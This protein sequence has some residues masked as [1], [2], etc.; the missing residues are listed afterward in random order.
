MTSHPRPSD[1]LRP[2]DDE[3]LVA[4]GS[5]SDELDQA[6]ADVESEVGKP[7]KPR[8]TEMHADADEFSNMSVDDADDVFVIDDDE[9]FASGSQST[10]VPTR[11]PAR[12][13]VVEPSPP[14]IDPATDDELLLN[15]D[16]QSVSME[17]NNPFAVARA[18]ST[19][20]AE[21]PSNDSLEDELFA[22]T[23]PLG[24]S[25]RFNAHA[26]PFDD[27]ES[28][29]GATWGGDQLS[30]QDIGINARDGDDQPHVDEEDDDAIWAAGG[31]SD[32]ELEIV[33]DV[34][35][36]TM[37]DFAIVDGDPA[38]QFG[39]Q[40]I[41]EEEVSAPASGVWGG[42]DSG[43][44]RAPAAWDTPSPADEEL[45]EPEAGSDS[46]MPGVAAEVGDVDDSEEQTSAD[47]GFDPIYGSEATSPAASEDGSAEADEESPDY[48]EYEAAYVDQTRRGPVLVGAPVGPRRRGALT[49]AAAAAL[50]LCGITA[51][52]AFMQP[53]WL[54]LKTTPELVD[55]ALIA[56]P[57]VVI[58]IGAPPAP[59]D[60][61]VVLQTPGDL[62][63]QT[64][65]K[66]TDPLT[67]GPLPTDPKPTDPTPP[68]QPVPDVIVAQT[69]PSPD[70]VPIPVPIPVPTDPPIGIDPVVVQQT[71][72]PQI[73]PEPT[74]DPVA[75]NN[76]IVRIGEDLAVGRAEP[77]S[78]PRVHHLAEGLV[79]GSQAF[80]QLRN[81]NFFLGRV[82]AMDSSFLTL[83]LTPGE[84]TIAFDDLN[85][86]VPLAS[87][88]YRAMQ[89]S[90]DGFV[91]LTNRNKLFGKIL[92]NSLA[93]NV[94]LEVQQNHVIIP[95]HTIE[96]VGNQT[97]TSVQVM[98]DED[99]DWIKAMLQRQTPPGK[100][101]PPATA[102]GGAGSATPPRD[103]R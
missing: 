70:P 42:A 20:G 73:T 65:L 64:D 46:D 61:P 33:E 83:D 37:G 98:Q 69:D 57:T 88:E 38:E 59:A 101:T 34:A 29:E 55:R 82:K 89:G 54:G 45:Q 21:L 14:S 7:T 52:F 47:E 62:V 49:L 92:T 36:G 97:R 68:I 44:R 43:T 79:T 3:P 66:P 76:D 99:A 12:A 56:R 96:E 90:A 26:P 77:P 78:R 15:D 13:K 28:T 25:E 67:T 94:V 102:P 41:D 6:F 50:I 71:P 63:A 4:D 32:Q 31:V 91:K 23:S 24:V 27:T 72:P 86:I 95:R 84:I 19:S 58:E 22:P 103:A 16:P 51:G 85:A 81:M 53:E 93:D 39:I 11:E 9:A 30:V 40:P 80:A 87:E 100:A 35:D 2:E 75:L 18:T 60:D 10:P 1:P 5:T 17:D 48:T 74:K 8:S